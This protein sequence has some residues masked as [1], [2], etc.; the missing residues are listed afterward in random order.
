MELIALGFDSWFEDHAK[1]LVKPEQSIAR[2][3]A[4][5]RGRCIVNDGF[6]EISAVLLGKYLHE[7]ESPA[8][9]PCVGDWVSVEHHDSDAF[10]SIHAILQRKTLLR[11]KTAGREIEFQMIAANI[12]TAFIV[13]SCRFDFNIRRLERYLVMVNEG[14]IEPLILL[15]KTDLISPDELELLMANIRSA[16]INTQ[17]IALSNVTGS[18]IEQ[19]RALMAAGKTYCLLGSSG[20]GKTTL[21]NRLVGKAE[22]E[23]KSV[24][25]T[26]EGRHTTT[27]RQLIMLEDGAMLIDMP[28]M[29]ELGMVGDS[30]GIDE[31]FSDVVELIA[32]CRFADCSHSNE[33]GC[34]ILMAI[35]NGELSE[36]HFQNYLKLNKES[37]FYQMSHH[38]KRKKDKAFGRHI[39]SVMKHR[40]KY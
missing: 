10:A 30:E 33:P 4:V 27:R 34:A 3:I 28:G 1:E 16:G 24:S 25:A 20:V 21:I 6:R 18:G 19:V 17:I 31:S 13:Q 12:D 32:N 40:D 36:D 39:K 35:E 22:L 2:V 9:F 29:R 23:T 5:D 8:D 11:R 7:I 37:D 15:T 26:G 14:Q 38:E